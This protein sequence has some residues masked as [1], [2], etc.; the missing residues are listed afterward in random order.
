V[1]CAALPKTPGLQ[2]ACIDCQGGSATWRAARRRLH[3]HGCSASM[4]A[5][6]QL[7]HCV[8][9]CAGRRCR[10]RCGMPPR[11]RCLHCRCAALGLIAVQVAAE[12]CCAASDVVRL[13]CAG[14]H[15]CMCGSA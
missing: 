13:G 10:K 1:P 9:A 8:R 6:L 7:Q 14:V 5:L 12:A 11:L 2:R 15:G 3:A 4:A